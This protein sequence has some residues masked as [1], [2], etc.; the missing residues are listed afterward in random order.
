MCVSVLP[1]ML[2]VRTLSSLVNQD[3]INPAIVGGATLSILV[4]YVRRRI[5]VQSMLGIQRI[6]GCCRRRGVT[7]CSVVTTPMLWV[8]RRST[9]EQHTLQSR[10]AP[11]ALCNWEQVV[12]ALCFRLCGFS[13]DRSI[14]VLEGHPHRVNSPFFLLRFFP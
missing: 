8:S 3:G 11:P 1:S 7:A 12:R 2:N 4:A 14:P 13:F 5:P 9:P 6:D 10:R